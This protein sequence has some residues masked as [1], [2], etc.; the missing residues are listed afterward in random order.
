MPLNSALNLQE[1]TITIV[2]QDN[3]HFNPIINSQPLGDNQTINRIIVDLKKYIG[4]VLPEVKVSEVE[5]NF[6]SLRRRMENMENQY[7]VVRNDLNNVSKENLALKTEVQDLNITVASLEEKIKK[8]EQGIVS[9]VVNS[10]SE[11][12]DI[13]SSQQS[14]NDQLLTLAQNEGD[15]TTLIPNHSM[16]RAD[17]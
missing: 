17:S 12:M 1:K 13:D 3:L 15:F 6:E 9:N 11:E 16:D 14:T 10:Y 5:N 7:K 2:N 4:S 8:A